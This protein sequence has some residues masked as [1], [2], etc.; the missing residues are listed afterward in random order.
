MRGNSF[1]GILLI[2]LGTVF[3]LVGMRKRGA[4]LIA[5]FKK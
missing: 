3:L 2:L 5:E 1:M 4:A